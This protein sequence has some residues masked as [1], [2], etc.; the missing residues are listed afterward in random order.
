MKMELF[1]A[2][3][4]GQECAADHQ[5]RLRELSRRHLLP[6]GR[7]FFSHSN[8]HDCDGRKFE[9]YLINVDGT[10]LEQVTNFGGFTAFPEFS[11]DGK[12]MVFAS[13]K[14]A[15]AAVRVQYFYG[16]LEVDGYPLWEVVGFRT[17]T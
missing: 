15:K 8:K 9:L 12:K 4:D 13:D 1:V 3:A 11:P 14:D 7:R 5:F 17:F 10:G 2:D 6:T 16:G